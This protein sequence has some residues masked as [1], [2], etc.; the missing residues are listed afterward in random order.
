M[1]ARLLAMMVLRAALALT[2]LGITSWFQSRDFS[3]GQYN[4]Y[5]LY[6]VVVLI[7]LLT[8]LYAATLNR[9]KNL[10]LFAYAQVTADI[11]IITMIV[12]VT[13]G[14]D[15]YLHVLYPLSVIGSAVILDKSGGYYAAS[16]SSMFYAVV[17]DLDFYRM[18]PLKYKVFGGRLSP[19]WEDV[20]TTLA[21][22]VLAYFTIAYLAGYLVER[23]ARV[24]KRL[25]EKEV[26]YDKLE[27]LNRYIVENISSGIMTL[28]SGLRVTS[29]NKS[30]EVITGYPLRDV[31]YRDLREVFPGMF[32]AHAQLTTGA[33]IE[34]YFRRTGG[35]E[36]C[37][38]YTVSEGRG[39]EASYIVIFN[40]LTEKKSMEERLRM[41]DRLRA[42]GELSVGI[43]HE[44]RNP[45]AS[46]S[47]SIQVLKNELD[48]GGENLQLMEIVLRETERLNSLISDY[49]LFA[50]PAKGKR[51]MVNLSGV[52]A[53]TFRI[54]KN[55]PEAADIKITSS[56]L[57][58]IYVFG[59]A[60]QLGQVFWNLFLN[61][62]H[63]MEGGGGLNIESRFDYITA[64]DLRGAS[65]GVNVL[66]T[67]SDTGR[68]IP[69]G[70]LNRIF[71]PF[72][73]TKDTG[74]GL[75]LAIVHRVVESHG[76]RIE[77]KS[78]VG[79]GSVFMIT[80][81]VYEADGGGV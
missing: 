57:P 23:T 55:C 45:L 8:I 74:T 48:L 10:T 15:S 9:A 43:A 34:R 18:L 70:D 78:S 65:P 80:L 35:A 7:G 67:V 33:G 31:Y 30:A 56:V 46:I 21:T 59:D 66:I 58:D 40:D 2:F 41:N 24:E 77:V 16:M 5:P 6:A 3:A 42:L 13:G 20:F 60:R 75:G 25:V 12:Y 72:F 32:D 63:A 49:L 1:K 54:F 27:T 22:N 36:I 29:F 4:F 38:G 64:D 62:S 79:K 19:A 50:R 39:G 81:P 71:D 61:A 68:G 52:I 53:E 47:G 76:G 69:P 37:L 73:S 51:E 14:A 28:D 17:V 44:I 26:D 11:I